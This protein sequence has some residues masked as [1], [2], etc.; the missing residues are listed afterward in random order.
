M[1]EI[2]ILQLIIYTCII[3]NIHH[4]TF[5]MYIVYIY[6]HYIHIYSVCIYIYAIYIYIYNMYIVFSTFY[7][8]QFFLIIHLPTYMSLFYDVNL[9]S[10]DF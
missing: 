4:I 9:G 10:E 8:L 2:Y 6:T 7:F 3:Y 5:S 1:Q